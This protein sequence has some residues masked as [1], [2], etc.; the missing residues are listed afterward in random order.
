MAVPRDTLPSPRGRSDTNPARNQ[1]ARSRLGRLVVEGVLLCVAAAAGLAV[2]GPSSSPQAP[3]VFGLRR[4]ASSSV[5]GSQLI[6]ESLA[7]RLLATVSL[8]PGSVQLAHAP[9]PLLQQ[10]AQVQLSNDRVVRTEFWMVPEGSGA[11]GRWTRS[12]PAPGLTQFESGTGYYGT[13]GLEHS[14]A[15]QLAPVP[16]GVIQATLVYGFAAI[17]HSRTGLRVDAEV[18]WR[19]ARPRGSLI[20][21]SDRFAELRWVRFGT[22]PER[23]VVPISDPQLLRRLI[24]A[25]NALPAVPGGVESCPASLLQTTLTFFARRGG[26]PGAVLS[27]SGCGQFMLTGP[28]GDALLAAGPVLGM[29]SNLIRLTGRALPA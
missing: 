15:W 18:I 26:A 19:P 17:G 14:L 20:A 11:F 16:P 6:A 4:V 25:V 5:A 12:S 7:R 3:T 8:P 1:K 13:Q 28:G 22:N 29:E 27:Y 2:L 9:D 24:T 23:G 10:S 21:L